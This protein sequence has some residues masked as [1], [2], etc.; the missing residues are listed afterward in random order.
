[1]MKLLVGGQHCPLTDGTE[2]CPKKYSDHLSI[3]VN[4]IGE[5]NVPVELYRGS[6]YIVQGKNFV[7][8]VL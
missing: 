3:H 6:M 4:I 5:Y 8:F 7:S 1:M 2:H